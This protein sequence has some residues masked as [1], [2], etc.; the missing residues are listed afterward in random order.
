VLAVSWTG[1]VICFY[2]NVC[3]GNRSR[4]GFLIATL[5]ELLLIAHGLDIEDYAL[6]AAC[7]AWICLH[8]RNFHRWSYAPCPTSTPTLD[9]TT[10]RP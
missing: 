5:G 2:G 1:W 7:T 10:S 9:D 6:V 8:G 3:I 4:W